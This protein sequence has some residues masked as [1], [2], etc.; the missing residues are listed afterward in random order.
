ME[1]PLGKPLL[2]LP[3]NIWLGV[4]IWSPF[5]PIRCL[6]LVNS[7]LYKKANPFLRD[8]ALK[9][10][11]KFLILFFDRTVLCNGHSLLPAFLKDGDLSA[12]KILKSSS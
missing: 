7:Q 10:F 2:I 11:K 8:H 6:Y 5:K 9:T 3:E 1:T 12:G 4:C